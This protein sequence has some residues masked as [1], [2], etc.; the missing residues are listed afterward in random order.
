MQVSNEVPELII[1][2]LVSN[3]ATSA[4]PQPVQLKKKISLPHPVENEVSV[5]FGQ[6]LHPIYSPPFHPSLVA[7]EHEFRYQSFFALTSSTAQHSRRRGR[8]VQ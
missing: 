7:H 6:D 4:S 2:V 5:P 8:P 3:T 1:F